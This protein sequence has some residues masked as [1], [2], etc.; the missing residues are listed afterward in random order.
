MFD[1]SFLSVLVLVVAVVSG[2][3]IGF[4]LKQS[5]AAKE[6][7]SSKNLMARMAE[8]AK[9]E[10]ETIKK[11]A[12]LQAKENLLK[13]KAEF[14]AESK[15]RRND[16][17]AREKRIRTKEENL[18]KK[19]DALAQKESSVESRE[20]SISSKEQSLEDKRRKLDAALHEQQERLEKI[21]G[22]SPEE[23]KNLLI[24]SMEAEA[25]QDAAALVR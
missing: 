8:E 13:M 23:A 25:K 1:A 20:K 15:E 14:D 6:I 24:K 22:I 11:E 19:T 5:I 9:K 21:A 16:F 3:I 4:I 12:V 7:R 17:E 18:D 2:I 10:A